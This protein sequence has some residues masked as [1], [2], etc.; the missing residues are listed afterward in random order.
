MLFRYCYVISTKILKKNKTWNFKINKLT[1]LLLKKWM[2]EI[3]RMDEEEEEKKES[4][5]QYRWIETAKL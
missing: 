2:E 3:I 4:N 5:K 1:H